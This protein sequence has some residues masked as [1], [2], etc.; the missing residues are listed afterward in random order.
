MTRASNVIRSSTLAVLVAA[1]AVGCSTGDSEPTA[2]TTTAAAPAPTPANVKLAVFERAYSECA[3]TELE[4][5]AAKYKVAEK[6]R[7]GVATAVGLAWIDIFKAGP[8]AL[9]DGRSGCL[10]GFEDR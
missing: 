9:P 2:A 8:D 1:L 4:R 7:P 6:T 5:L 10:Q 3:S